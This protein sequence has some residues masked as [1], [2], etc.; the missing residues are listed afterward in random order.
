MYLL[1]VVRYRHPRSRLLTLDYVIVIPRYC[2]ATYMVTPLMVTP[3]GWVTYCTMGR[4]YSAGDL[5][6][7]EHEGFDD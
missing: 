6:T 1:Y 7:S 3:V 2:R 5:G 4:Y